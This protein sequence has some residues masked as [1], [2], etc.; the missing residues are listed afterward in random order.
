MYQGMLCHHN[1]I[2]IFNICEIKQT[3]SANYQ[4]RR[5]EFVGQ[6]HAQELKRHIPV[7]RPAPGRLSRPGLLGRRA[8]SF[9]QQNRASGRLKAS[10]VAIIFYCNGRASCFNL[11][12][13]SAGRARA[14]S[15]VTRAGPG[16]VS[17][18]PRPA[19]RLA[20]DGRTLAAETREREFSILLNNDSEVTQARHG[21]RGSPGPRRPG[22]RVR[23][24][25]G[26]PR[27]SGCERRRPPG[28]PAG[29]LSSSH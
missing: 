25:P 5:D 15:P 7:F 10:E 27:D 8:T 14:E 19:G 11:E 26:R 21:R 24:G 12:L 6:N 4:K 23:R 29:H 18:P 16:H 20:A 13:K 9:W 1:G 28:P 2:S 17:D 3:D 22:L